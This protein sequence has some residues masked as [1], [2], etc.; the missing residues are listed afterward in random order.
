MRAHKVNKF[1]LLTAILLVAAFSSSAQEAHIGKLDG[2]RM[3]E[4]S[5]SFVTAGAAMVFAAM[6]T[7]KTL[8]TSTFCRATL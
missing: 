4:S 8:P 6:A 2:T 7:A 1:A 5:F 3:Q